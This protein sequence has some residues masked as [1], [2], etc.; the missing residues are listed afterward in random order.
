M[1]QVPGDA[2]REIQTALAEAPPGEWQALWDAFASRASGTELRAVAEGPGGIAPL[3]AWEELGERMPSEL[4][5]MANSWRDG[6][7][8]AAGAHAARDPKA[9]VDLALQPA[10]AGVRHAVIHALAWKDP[11]EARR[12]AVAFP[13]LAGATGNDSMEPVRR[14]WTRRDPAAAQRAGMLDV[15][16]WAR[17][18][19]LGALR[20]V[21]GA[22]EEDD[23][24]AKPAPWMITAALRRDPAATV[25]LLAENSQLADL[26]GNDFRESGFSASGQWYFSAPESCLAWVNAQA[27]PVKAARNVARS[28]AFVDPAAAQALAE[29][30][31]V[32]DVGKIVWL[33]SWL[34]PDP[35]LDFDPVTALGAWLAAA[36][37]KAPADAMAAAG[38]TPAQATQ[39]A[40]LAAQQFP[41]KA[42]QLAERVPWESLESPD[43]TVPKVRRPGL[44]QLWMTEDEKPADTGAAGVGF[45]GMVALLRSDP[46]KLATMTDPAGCR[47]WAA[48]N[49]TANW[50]LHD[51]PAAETWVRSLPEG[52]A[53]RRAEAVL[54][55]ESAVQNP[56]TGIEALATIPEETW[57]DLPTEGASAWMH[58]LH[59][60]ALRGEDWQDGLRR[61]PERLRKRVEQLR[62]D[63]FEKDVELLAV[64]ERAALAK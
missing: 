6:L 23:R 47:E 43:G 58:A 57:A 30:H 24:G 60:A 21:A 44:A 14:A 1:A 37:T 28:V 16:M 3:L 36:A 63:A 2:V 20:H 50:A 55:I 54:A 27:D 10:M 13:P 61:V 25:Q 53:R 8:A 15:A 11:A 29:R 17:V 40:A 48:S 38:L 62:N 39:L 42:R 56:A 4:T 35:A 5:H 31:G 26:C 7:A 32:A 9:A 46:A 34:V 19:P 18:D 33:R 12:L 49:V 52:R 64:L 59:R 22:Q 51:F 45:A 41:A